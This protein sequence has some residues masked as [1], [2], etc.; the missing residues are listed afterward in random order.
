MSCTW[1]RRALHCP[2]TW[3][4]RPIRRRPVIQPQRPSVQHGRYA[5]PACVAFHRGTLRPDVPPV[6]VF[7]K[8]D[9]RPPAENALEV[10]RRCLDRPPGC[11]LPANVFQAADGPLSVQNERATSDNGCLVVHPLDLPLA[12]FVVVQSVKAA[13]LV[14]TV[15][16]NDQ[17]IDT[18]VV[19]VFDPHGPDPPSD[20]FPSMSGNERRDRGEGPGPRAPWNLPEPATGDRQTRLPLSG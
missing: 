19:N 11:I 16:V 2:I 20:R 4:D 3:A 6:F 18:D 10:G 7:G 12:Q 5:P 13:D 9:Q 14:E 1:S 15:P 8:F 17:R